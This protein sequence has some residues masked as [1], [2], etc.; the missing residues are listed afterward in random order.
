[1]ALNVSA[2][3]LEPYIRRIFLDERVR[4]IGR[5]SSTFFMEV[6]KDTNARGQT[7]M[8]LVHG[9][10][11]NRSATFAT[12]QSNAAA[13][14]AKAFQIDTTAAA[15]SAGLA[16]DYGVFR[17]SNKH[18]HTATDTGAVV[19][20]LSL[21]IDGLIRKIK[22]EVQLGC[23]DPDGARVK[24]T[25]TGAS[26]ATYTF[27]NAYEAR[28]FQLGDKVVAAAT[29]TGALRDSGTAKTVTA[30]TPSGPSI[31]LNAAITGATTNDLMF[32]EG[33]AANTGGVKGGQGLPAW[34]PDSA[35]SST[36]FFGVDRSVDTEKLGGL[37][38]DGSSTGSMEEAITM[39]S[40][41]LYDATQGEARPDFV[42]TSSS[43]WRQ[44]SM[45]L[46]DKRL[47]Q[48]GKSAEFGYSY[49]EHTFGPYTMKVVPDPENHTT[50][51][52]MLDMSTWILFS[53]GDI[54]HFASEDGNR[55]LRASSDAGI[56]V[57]M[58]AFWQL[59]CSV[60]FFNNSVKLP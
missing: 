46:S 13:V 3:D 42:F 24:A 31:T 48:M 32:L 35:P 5:P 10:G 8:A 45:E 7:R 9:D 16:E 1:M 14:P 57:R 58:D 18:L 11:P 12:A 55:I 53:A 4:V 22:R 59:G 38:T 30:V 56:E 17:L 54:P 36:T 20:A 43:K 52:Y 28:R 51:G 41:A 2:T 6:R 34:I 26:S 44:L 37:R 25:I 60:P 40:E 19:S 47:G 15:S 33:D 50:R 21:G 27:G 49:I 39:G 23:Y 29:R